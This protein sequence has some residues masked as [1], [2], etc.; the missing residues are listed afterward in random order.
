M[1]QR[2]NNPKNVK[3]PRYGGRGIVVCERW[4]SFPAFL[5]DMGPKP[6]PAHTIERIDNDGNYEPA[7]CR[8][9]TKYEQNRNRAG[10][11]N[12]T[13][14]GET[15]TMTDWARRYGISVGCIRHRIER[16]WDDARAVTTPAMPGLQKI[17]TIFRWREERRATP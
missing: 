1:I 5:D 8:W 17:K 7:N 12:L 14:G 16:G 9:A 10:N 2:C 15:L 13:I 6:T 4:K 11:R 3:Y